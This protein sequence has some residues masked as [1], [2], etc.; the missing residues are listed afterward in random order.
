MAIRKI[1]KVPDPVLRGSAHKVESI[2][3]P[4]TQE[5]IGDMLETVKAAG[6]VG[7][8]APQVGISKQIIIIGSIKH[9]AYPGSSEVPPYAVINPRISLG[10]SKIYGFE[11]CLSIPGLRGWVPR[12]EIAEVEYEDQFGT[13][14]RNRYHGLLARAFQHEYDHLQGTLF[15]DMT[16][17][18]LVTEK[19]YQQLLASFKQTGKWPPW[20]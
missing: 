16:E 7:L 6:G 2:S 14:R 19:V 3:D 5:L 20:L 12:S 10:G 9:P 8:A 18:T 17:A 15:T 4:E 1:V 13:I 11:G